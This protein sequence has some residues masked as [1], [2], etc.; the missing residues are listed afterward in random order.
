MHAGDILSKRASLT[1][2]R[3]ALVEL[4]TGK[5]YTYGK[6]NTKSNRLANFLRHRLDIKKGERI[7]ILAHNSAAYIELFFGVGK[8]GA[9]LVPLNW[10]LVACELN[11]IINNCQP[12]AIFCGPE[13]APVLSEI[14]SEIDIEHF[15]SLEG[16]AIV[17]AI[18][19]EK[20]SAHTRQVEPKRP[21]LTDEDPYCILYTSGTTGRPKGAVIPHRQ[22]LWNCINTI[23]S[24]EV[25]SQDISPV[26]TPLFHAGGL[27]AF[28]TP[29]FYAGGR[30]I[31]TRTFDKDESLKIIEEHKC[32]VV[33]GVPSLFQ[34][35]MNS[36][37]FNEV[38]FNCV[39]WF[40][41]GGAP[42]PVS[43]MEAWRSAKGVVFRQGYGL[44]EAGVNCCTMTND[45]S[46][47]KAG[48][49]GKPIFHSSMRVVNDEGLDVPIGQ[50][51]ELIIAGPHVFSGYWRNQEADSETLK[52][53]WLYT[54][55]AAKMDKDG[56]I[57]IV[58]RFKDM[59]ISGGENI[60]A[61]EVES[62]FREHPSIEDAALIGKPDDKWGEI[63]VMVV[64]LRQGYETNKEELIKFC[65]EHLAK[66]KIPKQIIFMDFLPYSSYGKVMKKEL[67]KRL[68]IDKKE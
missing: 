1:H 50:T 31:L 54:G 10:R 42:C 24:W 57:Y 27:F 9:V 60:Y 58:G 53:G 30:I 13:F 41:S 15:V 62:V 20:E 7:C 63:G 33:L 47:L 68:G 18:S 43:L 39:R 44:T 26:F 2:N 16:A 14:R 55:D 49:V 21:A 64:V 59:I 52:D 22:V 56:F 66:Y 38:N 12:K 46:V 51:G 19:Y 29:L 37:L 5:H 32:T 3:T 17:N 36:S 4:P 8:I 67:K 11:Y 45:E 40:I 34:I 61:T 28:L 35:W 48:S 23:I 25:T 65:Q 6:L